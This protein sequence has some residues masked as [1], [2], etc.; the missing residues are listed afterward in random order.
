M[1]RRFC[2]V[3]LYSAQVVVILLRPLLQGR[4]DCRSPPCGK[5]GEAASQRPIPR[6]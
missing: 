5:G 6:I 2:E 1:A 4:G 3:L